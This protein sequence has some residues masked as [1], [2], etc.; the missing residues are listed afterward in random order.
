MDTSGAPDTRASDQELWDRVRSGDSEAFGLLFARHGP[1]VFSYCFHRTA[2]WATAEDL[3]STVFLETWRLRDRFTVEDTAVPLLLGIAHR[4]TQKHHRSLSRYRAALSRLPPEADEPDPADRVAS[5]LDAERRM[6][7]LR[8][9]LLALPRREREVV[10][11]CVFGELEYA[12]AARALG[13]PLGT[14]RSRM[15]RARS[16]LRHLALA[17]PLSPHSTP[18]PTAGVSR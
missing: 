13:I 7:R 5:R 9:A 15:S 2:S 16:R 17:D 8:A 10:E 3:V 11:L 18:H 12:A 14:V 4:V 6:R 1:T